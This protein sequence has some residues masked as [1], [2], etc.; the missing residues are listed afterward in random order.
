[1]NK[2]PPQHSEDAAWVTIKTPFK[3]V[4]LREMLN[5]I[6]RLYRINSL[7]V[8]EQWRQTG[9]NQYMFRARNL[10]NDKML[11]TTLYVQSAGDVITIRYSDGL[12]TTTTLRI[13]PQPGDAANLIVTDD[14]SR[15]SLTER[16]AR[17][18]EVDKSLVQWGMDLHRYF[19]RWKK[20][21]W[22]PGWQFYMRRIWQPMKPAARR[23][24][25]LL[26]VI[27]VAEFIVFLFVFTIFWLEMGR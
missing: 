22:V 9:A 1:M 19:K 4:Q 23:I 16:Q 17:I 14:Y 13:D 7:L 18:E 5:D 11:E 26:I 6:E 24:A 21:S 15:T 2:A 20:W 8:F 27:T 12:K 25:F 3:P 10:S